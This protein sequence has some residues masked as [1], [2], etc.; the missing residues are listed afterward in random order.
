VL[1]A[2]FW[3][4]PF[5]YLAMFAARAL[6]IALFKPLFD[7]AGSGAQPQTTPFLQFDLWPFLLYDH[8]R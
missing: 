5:V 4:L 6:S 1:F 2:T 3:R 8:V 7:L